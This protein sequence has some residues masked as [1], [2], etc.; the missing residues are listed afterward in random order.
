MTVVARE[1]CRAATA[2]QTTS[3]KTTTMNLPIYQE[4]LAEFPEF[5]G[6]VPKQSRWD[7]LE[8]Y[9]WA[10]VLTAILTGI[11]FLALVGAP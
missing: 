8:G 11:G 2:H 4:T 6:P 9:V 1:G 10:A 5:Y 7:V 3:R